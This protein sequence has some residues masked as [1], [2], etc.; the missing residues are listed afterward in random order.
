MHRLS[1]KSTICRKASPVP[2]PY[3]CQAPAENDKPIW[4]LKSRSGGKK[5]FCFF[6]ISMSVKTE[7]LQRLKAVHPL[8]CVRCHWA[9]IA[10]PSEL[11]Y[12]SDGIQTDRVWCV[13]LFRKQSQTMPN[14]LQQSRQYVRLP[15][16][17]P[18]RRYFKCQVL[19]MRKSTSQTG[20]QH[21]AAPKR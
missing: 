12:P 5:N 19:G 6:Q 7:S 2:F 16:Q 20:R 10:S 14:F 13:L 4:Q 11:L 1:E 3:L 21:V 15:V 8:R 18:L 9:S 17:T